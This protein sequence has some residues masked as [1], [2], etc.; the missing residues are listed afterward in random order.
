MQQLTAAPRDGLTADQVV[1]ILSAP[2][3]QVGAGLHQLNA[4]LEQVADL[5]DDL[6]AGSVERQMYATVHGTCKLQLARALSWGVDLV[7]PYMDLSDGT[8]TARFYLGV[9]ALTTPSTAAGVAPV[10][11]DV[12]GYDRLYLLNREVG[13][14]WEAPAGAGVLAEARRAI[15][16]AGLVG[17][18]LDTTAEATVLPTA[19][20]WPLVPATGGTGGSGPATWLRVVNDLLASVNYTGL[21]TDELGIFRSGPYVAPINRQPEWTFDSADPRTILGAR[22]ERTR[23]VWATPNR[24]VIVQQNRDAAAGPPSGTDGSN[25]LYVVNDVTTPLTGQTARGQVWPRQ[26]AVDAAD[27]ASLVAVGDRIVAADKRVTATRTSTTG[28]FPPAGHFDVFQLNDA[29]L[30]NARV[31]ASRW[32]LDLG[33]KDTTWTWE[34]VA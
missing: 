6:Q 7:R 9:F 34:E 28:P 24:W 21:W 30:G 10:V 17:V 33:G 14:S 13:D 22:R 5:T 19:M 25:G 29:E 23:D 1:A 12:T 4:G 2:A 11:Y 32:A 26:V 18:Q 8:T 16:A 27:A 20:S 3:L 15:A 31:L